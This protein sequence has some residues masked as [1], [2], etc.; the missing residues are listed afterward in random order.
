MTYCVNPDCE[1]PQNPEGVECC[2]ACNSPLLLKNRFIA[3]QSI[4]KGNFGRTLLAKDADRLHAHCVIKQFF[5]WRQV[6]DR[7]EAMEKFTYRFKQEASLLLQLGAHPQIPTLFACFEQDR[8]LYLVQEYIEGQTLLEELLQEGTFSEQK[9]RD[10]LNQLLPVLKFIHEQGVIHRDIKPMNVIRRQSDR[11]LILIDFGLAKQLNP[12]SLGKTGSRYGTEG[13]APV[14]QTR[15]KV[16]PASD[17]YSLGATCIQ[18]LTGTTLEELY[19]AEQG[20]WVW[21][22]YLRNK[23]TDVSDRLSQILDKLL[24]DSLKERYQSATE[25][26]KDLQET[27]PRWRCVHTLS[28]HFGSV[29]KVTFSPDGQTLASGS[30]DQTLKVWQLSNGELIQSVGGESGGVK[31][32][33]ISSDGQTL[34]SGSGDNTIQLWHLPTEQLL[35]T[36]AGH[37]SRVHQVAFTPDGQTLVSASQD[38]TIKLWHPGTGKLLNTLT[39]HS[40][41]VGS[42][43]VSPDGKFLASG[44]EDK[45]IKIWHLGSGVVLHTLTEHLKRVNSLCISPDSQILASGSA[46][47]T[48]KIWH[49]GN[50]KLMDILWGHSEPVRSVAFSP[51]GQTIASGSDDKTIKLWQS[52]EVSR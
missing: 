38:S 14:E 6:Q 49:L 3:I 11:K 27:Q 36:L 17:L 37:Y 50:G 8:R 35:Y 32:A 16:Y 43:V 28:G 15:G 51:D 33:V 18:L 45:T 9:I 5:K 31:F 7:A 21:R 29:E 39:G 40:G 4:E 1:N 46:D 24:K 47:N 13:Y 44:S 20:V 10:L 30:D 42:I 19:E 2:L 23:G 52:D 25:V 12:S 41:G 22:D 26:L 48:I 34:A